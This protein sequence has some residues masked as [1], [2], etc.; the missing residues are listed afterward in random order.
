M[1]K[2]N[3]GQ[4]TI[5]EGMTGK[6]CVQTHI[7]GVRVELI[8]YITKS[9]MKKFGLDRD[10]FLDSNKIEKVEKHYNFSWKSAIK[11]ASQEGK[12]SKKLTKLI[13]KVLKD[14]E[15]FKSLPKEIKHIIALLDPV[16]IHQDLRLVPYT[17]PKKKKLAS[18]FEGGHWTTPG[19]Q[20]KENKLLRINEHIHLQFMLKTPHADEYSGQTKEPVIRG[21]SCVGA[22]TLILTDEGYKFA[23]EIKEGDRVY[24]K[25][26][27]FRR[28]VKV[29][30]KGVSNRF[31]Y[32]KPDGSNFAI[33]FNNHRIFTKDGLK[34]EREISPSKDLLLLPKPKPEIKDVNY[35]E[36]TI[37]PGYT[38]RVPVN[39]DFCYWLGFYVGDGH[40]STSHNI[41]SKSSTYMASH[42]V[43]IEC[44]NTD[45]ANKLIQL[46]K[47]LFKVDHVGVC[48]NTN[49]S[50]R[51]Y[52][53]G[54]VTWLKENC[55][56]ASKE[57]LHRLGYKSWFKK[58]PS[59]V[60]YL[61][62]NKL[63]AVFKGLM[64]SDGTKLKNIKTYDAYS[65]TSVSRHLIGQVLYIGMR[66]GY[67]PT[68][69]KIDTKHTNEIIRLNKKHTIIPK[70]TTYIVE[71]HK[72][73]CSYSSPKEEDEN[74]WY[75][76]INKKSLENNSKTS[77]R[78]YDFQVEEDESFL[79]GLL[80]VHNSWLNIGAKEPFVVS[81]NSIGST[82]NAY[83]FFWRHDYG[84]WFAGRQTSPH[85]RH[86]KLF[87]F[88]GKLL[89]D[90][91][92]FMYAPIGG[93]RIWICY[94]PKEKKQR[95]YEE[96]YFGGKKKNIDIILL[97]DVELIYSSL[98]KYLNFH[99]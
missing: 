14:E 73:V 11:E 96:H 64:D 71:F 77:I 58:L 46:T 3:T 69:R 34:L 1:I 49:P 85:G 76:S 61:P 27:R 32:I 41:S 48:Y 42:G 10:Y 60:L 78:L 52:D 30:E 29:M 23:C 81:P 35:I 67:Y 33:Y 19:N 40:V 39:E 18:Y 63:K 37:P 65:Y 8:D 79:T 54:L 83:A 62:D 98:Y 86:F 7:R 4:W 82:P 38:K 57:E 95:E 16:S 28:V 13:D 74:F 92:V 84:E 43:S 72:K 47:K 91:I 36:L 66:L 90:W 87:K 26:G 59:W 45:E 93:R 75:Y 50:L 99:I 55:Y 88:K 70:H 25:N 12:S 24:T 17:D 22:Y 44:A 20:F 21:P 80:V 68:L 2:V 97:E 15:K 89:N 56:C 53:S 6:Y 51:F 31:C 5:E 9:D 94:K